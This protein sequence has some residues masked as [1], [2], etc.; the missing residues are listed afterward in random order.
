MRVVGGE[1]T[2][3]AVP[4]KQNDGRVT[5][6]DGQ[7]MRPVREVVAQTEVLDYMLANLDG[8]FGACNDGVL[9]LDQRIA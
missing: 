7:R 1:R 3:Y 2:K 8:T 5:E 9:V 4:S 6:I